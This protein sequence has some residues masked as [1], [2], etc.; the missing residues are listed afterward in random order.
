MVK[1]F[2]FGG[3]LMFLDTVRSAAIST[4]G[5]APAWFVDAEFCRFI[6]RSDR[7]GVYGSSILEQGDLFMTSTVTT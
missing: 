7:A 2:V 3:R 6:L 4:A 5:Q 1:G